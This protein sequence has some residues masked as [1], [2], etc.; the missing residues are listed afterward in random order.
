MQYT[1]RIVSA[2][3]ASRRSFLRY[4]AASPTLTALAQSPDAPAISS[5]Q[6]AISIFD[7]MAPAEKNIPPQHWAYLMTGSDDNLTIEAN[8]NG[9]QLYQIRARRFID[10]STI[11]TSVE[12][13]GHRYPSPVLIAPCGSQQAFHPQG[14]LAVARAA[15]ARNTQM[16]LSTVTSTPIEQVAK[17][18]GQAPWYQLYP[19][20][21]FNITRQLI[22]RAGAAGSPVLVL[23]VDSAA[24]SNREFLNRRFP[25]TLPLCATCHKPGLQGWF[26]EHPMFDGIDTSKLT[27]FQHHYTWDM[28]DRIRG[29][30]KMKLV[31][32]GIVTAEDAELCV[33][34]GLDGIIVSNHGGRQEESLMGTIEALPEVVQAVNGRI[35]VLMD[36]GI[37]R[38]TDV[39]KALALGAKAVAIGRPYLWGLGA[40]GQPGVERVLD[41]LQREIILDMKSAGTPSI[42]QITAA[43]VRR[44]PA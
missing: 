19:G 41:I 38:G 39:F 8:R 34:Q 43:S 22:E 44:R 37:R 10:V 28:V 26:R 15:R 31:A 14:E 36:G 12:I 17:E 35:P 21:D 25:K 1:H 13:F 23:T 5:P 3:T 9:F 24:S 18:Y 11:D 4:V 2:L 7:L 32:K 20:P 6:D 16:I 29:I 30:T 42:A 33:K 27:A 40:F